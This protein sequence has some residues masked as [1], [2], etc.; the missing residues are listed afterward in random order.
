MLEI[1]FLGLML[2]F[3]LVVW[4]VVA[5]VRQLDIVLTLADLLQVSALR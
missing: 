5:S 2:R 4:I 1:E 3:L